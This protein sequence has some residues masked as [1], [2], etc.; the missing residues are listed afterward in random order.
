M[1]IEV[2]HI[3]AVCMSMFREVDCII[4]DIHVRDISKWTHTL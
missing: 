4:I 3:S 2:T 1:L